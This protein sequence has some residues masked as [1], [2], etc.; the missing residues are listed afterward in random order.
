MDNSAKKSPAGYAPGVRMLFT[1]IGGSGHLR[2]LLPFARA[3]QAA[4]HTIAVAGTGSLQDE[5]IAAG[6]AALPTSEPRPR[7]AES[8]LEPLSAP[9]PEREERT[10]REAFAGRGARRHAEVVGRIARE[11]KPDVIV[12]DEVDFGTAIAA[13]T[14]R[15]PCATV[16][17]LLA[18]GLIRPDVVAEPLDTLRAEY[19]LAPDPELATL[20]RDLL[21]MPA[22]PILRGPRY[23]LPGETFWCRP[24]GVAPEAS[25]GGARPT[26]YFTLGTFDA[27]RELFDRILTG[28]R[29]LP[30]NLVVTVSRRLDPASFGPQP[31]HIRI[32]SFIPQEQILPSC[33]L[34]IA[35][36]G[37]G[38]LIGSLAHGLP[39]L[40]MPLGADQPHN[41]RRCVELGTAR[42]LDPMTF[43]AQEAADAIMDMTIGS[44]GAAYRAAARRVRADIIALPGPEQAVALLER[45]P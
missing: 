29:D 37:S 34:V 30:V 16:M 1:F 32:E 35:H 40:L 13:E 21:I 31:G 11:W 45:L 12:R 18:G 39:S 6:F 5:I 22:P 9:D 2:P 33:D 24:D 7:A 26:V 20:Q 10:M 38:T 19:G 42:E 17:V 43:T 41:C 36:G 3:A 15:I 23:P 27:H 4:G 14:L 28:A 8:Q 44:A 25:G